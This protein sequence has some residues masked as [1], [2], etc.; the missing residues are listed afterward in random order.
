[1]PA[2]SLARLAACA[3]SPWFD[4]LTMRSK[5]LKQLGLILSF[6]EG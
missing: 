2:P 5:P 1:M 4:K 3:D 6:V